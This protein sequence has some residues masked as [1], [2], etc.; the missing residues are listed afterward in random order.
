MISVATLHTYKTTGKNAV[1]YIAVFTLL[2]KAE[3]IEV[4]ELNGSKHY[5]GLMF[6]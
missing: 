1:L 5:P 3:K 4:S 2:G 6:S